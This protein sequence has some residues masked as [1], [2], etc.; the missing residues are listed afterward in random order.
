MPG[1]AAAFERLRGYSIELLI[2][3]DL[4]MSSAPI[5]AEIL[6]VLGFRV[7]LV[8]EDAVDLSPDRLVFASGAT[9]SYKR[10]FERLGAIRA[11][12]RPL[13]LVWH[14]EPLPMPRAAGLRAQPLT[15]RELGKIVLRDRRINDHYSNAR[16]LRKLARS[17]VADVIA[18]ATKAYEAYLEQ[19]GLATEF[20]PL[21]YHPSQGRLLDLA[22]DID[23]AFLGDFRLPRRRRILRASSGKAW[24][25]SRSA[26]TRTPTSGARGGWR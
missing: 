13:V 24:T 23:V 20:V 18:V 2:R 26:T 15:V 3:E 1:V 22:R 9:R 16:F 12:R 5:A 7:R 8:G 11:A 6:Q 21:G 25:S 17:G 19:E 4:A 10:T 14:T